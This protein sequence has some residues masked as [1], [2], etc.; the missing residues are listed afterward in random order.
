MRRNRPPRTPLHRFALI[1]LALCTL[2][3]GYYLG[4]RYQLSELQDSAAILF[5]Q[6]V[7]T[8]PTHLP[9]ELREL[10]EVERRWVILLPVKVWLSDTLRALLRQAQ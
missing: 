9:R 3:L 6:P 2:L 7:D 10:I 8:A 4:N 5:E 1:S